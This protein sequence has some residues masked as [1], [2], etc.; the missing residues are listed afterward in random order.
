MISAPRIASHQRGLEALLESGELWTPADGFVGFRGRAKALYDAAERIARA[1]AV[2][3]SDEEW[4]VPPAVPL[5]TLARADYFASF[6]QWL[7]GVCHL[8]Q[9]ADDLAYIAAHAAPAQPV[10]RQMRGSAVA[11]PPAVCYQAYAALADSTL[12]G[13]VTLTA[14]GTCWRRE[15][16]GFRALERGWAFTMRESICIGDAGTVARFREAGAAA[17]LR[18]AEQLQIDADLVPASDPFFAPNEEARARGKALLQRVQELKHEL[19]VPLGD[20]RALA[21]GSVNSH[22]SFF[23]ESFDIRLPTGEP[24]HSA[25]VAFGVERLVL[26]VL[27]THGADPEDW[28]SEIRAQSVRALSVRTQ[29]GVER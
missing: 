27:A 6:P 3:L 25:C 1:F 15:E 11:L 29:S 8:S 21:V 2:E 22:G 28:P 26:A 20:R 13:T 18:L 23:G 14:Q 16:K 9:H 4:V 10:Q 5:H 7:C 17:L 24:A 12:S 19:Q